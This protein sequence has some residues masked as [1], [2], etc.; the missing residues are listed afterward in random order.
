MSNRAAPVVESNIN[1]KFS[2]LENVIQGLDGSIGR[3]ENKLSPVM[4]NYPRSEGTDAGSKEPPMC[5]VAAQIGRYAEMIAQMQSR[6][7]DITQRVEL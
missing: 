6:I 4:S 7:D 5:Q 2:Q 3:L 1:A